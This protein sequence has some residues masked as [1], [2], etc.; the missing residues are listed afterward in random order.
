MNLWEIPSYFSKS[1]NS[2]ESKEAAIKISV[3]L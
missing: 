2:S 1:I 3:K